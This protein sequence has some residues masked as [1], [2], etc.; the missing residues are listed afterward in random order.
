MPL[1]TLI[2]YPGL[3]RDIGL[4][5]S[6]MEEVRGQVRDAV[7][8]LNEQQ[9]GRPAFLG[10]HPI[11][12]LV[13]HIGE[14]EWWWLQCIVLGNKI[15]D[16]VR[17]MACWDVLEDPEGFAKRGYTAEYCLNEIQKIRQQTR[18]LLLTWT[19]ADLEK[20]YNIQKQDGLHEHTLRWILHHLIDH[21]SQHKGQILMLKR[22]W[23]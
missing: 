9:I 15:D 16:A 19:D 17:S 20:T 12:A 13:L 22:I 3:S 11:G 2:P 1:H 7:I 18:E 23:A 21:E 8:S 10:S 5:F 14:A 4:L 6:G